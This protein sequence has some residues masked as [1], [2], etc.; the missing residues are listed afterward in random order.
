VRRLTPAAAACAAVLALAAG[1]RA[2]DL[3]AIPLPAA[4][5]SAQPADVAWGL[6]ATAAALLAVPGLA[7]FYGGMVRRK[8]VLGTMMHVIVALAVVGVQWVLVGYCLTFGA[9][10][11][12]LVGWS[13]EFLGLADPGLRDAVAP[14]TRLPVVVHCTFHGV[15]AVLAP[16]LVAGAFAER[17]RFGPYCLFVMLWATLVYDPLAHW[18]WAVGADGRP[19]GWLGR[20]GVLDFAG[21]AVVHTAAGFAGLAAALILRRR[22]GY[23]ERALRPNALLMTLTGAGLLWLGWLGLTGGRAQAAGPAAGYAL[24]ATQAAAAA[25]GL[26]WLLVEWRHA[27]R[28]TAL[29]LASGVLAG[30]VAVSP[31]AGFVPPTGALWLGLLAGVACYAAVCLKSSLHYDDSLDVFG[32]HGAGGVLGLLLTGVFAAGWLR[33][34]GADGLL[35]QLGVQLLAAA[36][37]AGYAFGVTAGLIRVLDR[38]VGFCLDPEAEEAGLDRGVHGEIGL[39]LDP[40]EEAVARPVYAAP[41]PADVPPEGRRRFTVVVEG[42]TCPELMRAWSGLCQAGNGLP[43]AEFR[44]VYPFLTTVEGNRFHFRGGDSVLLR[45]SLAKLFRD[46]LD[47]APIRTYVESHEA[48]PQVHAGRRG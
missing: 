19:A 30:L 4:D 37:A 17:V 33:P 42:A 23:P 6:A 27:G 15:V 8:N 47:G 5:R 32:V 22:H 46:A 25:A 38:A 14:G 9:S 26:S 45:E 2:A 16:A 13:P 31:A 39:D 7:L 24:A 28:P 12:G 3:P 35:A 10:C 48:E 29:G 11:F 21:G 18:V 44:T 20:L 36:A 43:S 41:R 40:L 34:A 1:A